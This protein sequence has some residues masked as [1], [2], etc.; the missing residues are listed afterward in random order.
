MINLL[1][2]LQINFFLLIFLK[3]LK[4]EYK[5][6]LML[7]RNESM[8]QKKILLFVNEKVALIY[9]NQLFESLLFFWFRKYVYQP[10]GLVETK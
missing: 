3:E 1:L 9:K 6:K 8:K 7:D 5:T 10:I 2:P 4:K